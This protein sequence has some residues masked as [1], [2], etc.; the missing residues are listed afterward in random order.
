MTLVRGDALRLP[1]R[2]RSVDLIITSP[3]YFALRSYQDDGAHYAGQIGSEPTPADFLTAL[4]AVTDELWRVLK[5]TG[6]LFVNLGD[7]YAGSGGHNNGNISRW[8]TARLEGGKAQLARRDDDENQS[9]EWRASRRQAPDRYTQ[10]TDVP[11][12]S[13]MGLPWRY[14]L[15]LTCP[16]TYRPFAHTYI[17]AHP[18]WTLRAEL[19]WNK[20][21][22]LPESVTDRV[23]RSHEQWFHL[24]KQGRYYAAVDEVREGY[25]PGTAA[26]YLAG[27]AP[28]KRNDAGIKNQGPIRHKAD[29]EWAPGTV[30]TN[31]LGK[32]PGSV[33]T[34][35]S[36]PLAVPDHLGIDH[37]AAFPTEWP[38]RLILGW[39]PNGICVKCREGRVPVVEKEVGPDEQGRQG[40]PKTGRAV[41]ASP[42]ATFKYDHG[43]SLATIT[44]YR[45]ACDVPIAPTTPAIVFD[46][47]V[48]TGTVPLVART[49]GRYGIGVD[50]SR[51]YLRLAHWRIHHSGHGRKAEART[52]RERQGS[53]W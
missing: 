44:G 17:A 32:L 27:Y 52:N 3:P 51:D 12:K 30:S 35:P 50:L 20:P 8:A 2:D 40:V 48:G 37:Y 53:L 25:S 1:L 5:P 39:S 11:P 38:R 34:I 6:S 9:R 23:R 33:W 31:P 10:T 7:K 21:N 45:C 13:L 43:V 46:P 18:Q 24:T 4:W 14:A 47:F 26:R 49:L 15:G 16:E 36:E 19:V 22:G 28:D 41:N 29:G 42:L